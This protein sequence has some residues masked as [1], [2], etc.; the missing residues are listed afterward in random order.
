MAGNVLQVV[1]CLPSKSKALSSNLST[2]KTSDKNNK[3][4]KPL[5][6]KACLEPA[7][8]LRNNQDNFSCFKII[9]IVCQSEQLKHRGVIKTLD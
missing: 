7:H 8:F 4:Q 1:E 2:E 6:A 3:T 9:L 5:I